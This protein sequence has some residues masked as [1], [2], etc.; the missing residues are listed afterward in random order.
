MKRFSV[1]FTVFA[2]LLVLGGAASANFPSLTP[3]DTTVTLILKQGFYDGKQ[4]WFFCT[5]SN[6]VN[7]A[8]SYQFPYRIPTLAAPL[9][10]AYS[11]D[12]ADPPGF[13]A[14]MYVNTGY[15][16]G[17]VFT[18]VPTLDDYSGIWSV[19]FIKWLPGKARQV[20]NTNDYFWDTNPWGFPITTPGPTQQATL[21]TTYGTSRSPVVVDCPIAAVGPLSGSVWP[22]DNSVPTVL[23]RLPQVVAFNSKYKMITLPAWYTYCQERM[24]GSTTTAHFFIDKCTVII[25]DVEDLILADRLGA[26]R[27]PGL[28]HIDPGNTQDFFFIDGRMSAQSPPP[29]FADGGPVGS[30][31]KPNQY[32]ILEWCPNGIGMNNRNRAYTP[33]MDVLLLEGG[34]NFPTNGGIPFAN[35]WPYVQDLITAGIYTPDSDLRINAP[36]M[37]FFRIVRPQ[38]GCSDCP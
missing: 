14:I 8:T 7:F 25:P 20:T 29:F 2:L 1:V 9:S 31:M 35:S 21:S 38:A 4:V 34:P 16:Q 15:Q 33:V 11:F 17:P 32:P 26:N 18:A 37:G 30:L 12:P 27:A 22:R 13:G 19:V 28:G 10:S 24:L 3:P 6:D 5:D 36:V 23:Y